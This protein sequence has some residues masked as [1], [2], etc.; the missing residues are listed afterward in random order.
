MK[1]YT[2]YQSSASYRVRI[3]LNL[4]GIQA[5]EAYI[6]LTK[7]QQSADDY[8]NVNPQKLV[9]SLVVGKAVLTQ[10]IAIMEYL[11]ETQPEPPILPRDPIARAQARAIALAVAGDIATINNLKIRN[12]LKSQFGATDEEVKTKW[13]QHWIAEGFTALETLL[14]RSAHTGEFCIGDFPTIADCCLVPQIFNARRFG[15]DLTAFSTIN[16]I[17]AACEAH[18][19]FA[20]AHPSKQRD[21][22]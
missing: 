17:T 9:P 13:I 22:A 18:P 5:E 10:S 1:L 15:C 11:D 8:A 7:G 21:A 4:K 2:Y 20:A 12:R 6:D 3:A 14:A 19:A 16:R